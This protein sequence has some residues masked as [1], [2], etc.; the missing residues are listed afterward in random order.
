M[1][2]NMKAKQRKPRIVLKTLNDVMK[3]NCKMIFK[4]IFTRA[5]QLANTI[6]ERNLSEN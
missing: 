5:S 2:Y 3:N 6:K 1:M 4:Q